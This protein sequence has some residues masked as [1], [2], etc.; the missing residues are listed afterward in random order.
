MNHLGHFLLANLLL[1]ELEA[2]GKFR[3][4]PTYRPRDS[5]PSFQR[6]TTPALHVGA[7]GPS[8]SRV[9]VTASEVHDPTSPG[10]SVGAGATLGDLSGLEVNGATFEMIDGKAYDPDKAYKDSKV[11]FWW[12]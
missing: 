6:L 4:L 9:V 10:G 8:Y 7:N 1:P 5:R 12:R 11:R 3:A 2:A